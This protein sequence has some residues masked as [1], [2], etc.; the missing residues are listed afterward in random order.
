MNTASTIESPI[1]IR[2]LSDGHR[3]MILQR[4]MSQPGTLSQLAEWLQHSPAWVRHHLLVLQEAGLVEL[5][6]IRKRERVTE[7]YYRAKAA[8][9]LIQHWVLPK[10]D[11][12][13]LIFCGSHDLAVERL[14]ELVSKHLQLVVLPVGSLNGLIN[15]RQGVCQVAGAHIYDSHSGEYNIPTLRHLFPDWALNVVTLA[16]RVQ[17]LIVAAGNPKGVFGLEDIVR[18]D[19]RF[20]NRNEGSGTRLWFDAELRKL[21]IAPESINGYEQQLSTH[22]QTARYVLEGKADAALG[23]QA[24]AYQYGLGFIPLFEERYDLVFL[25]QYNEAMRPIL[26]FISSSQYQR[27]TGAL[28]GYNL[29]HSGEQ[30]LFLK[31]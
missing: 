10:S 1:Q 28:P 22:T 27:Q 30:I 21:G 5:V 16:R 13:L 26:D 8:A 9:Y 19:I 20:V 15:L 23:L 29:A 24:A 7:K 6:E 12:P 2:A 4:L 31:G 18:R 25:D 11:K 17:G 14:A 3:L